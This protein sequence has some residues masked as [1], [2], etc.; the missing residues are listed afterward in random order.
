MKGITRAAWVDQCPGK[1]RKLLFDRQ[2]FFLR[3]RW[4]EEG[5]HVEEKRTL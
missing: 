5:L 4:K 1:H 2:L 3:L